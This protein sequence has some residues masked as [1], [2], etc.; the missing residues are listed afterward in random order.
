MPG[1]S[2]YQ[3]MHDQWSQATPPDPQTFIK[4]IWGILTPH[5]QD[6][7]K[8]LLSNP[9]PAAPAAGTTATP[10]APAADAGLGKGPLGV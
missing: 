7:V 9:M 3:S 6:L 5:Q 10:Q 8:A 4:M 2:S 1:T